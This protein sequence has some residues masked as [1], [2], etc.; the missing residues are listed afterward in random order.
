M[1]KKGELVLS[2]LE[3]WRTRYKNHKSQTKKELP[4]PDYY[5]VL[6]RVPSSDCMPNDITYKLTDGVAVIE[7]AGIFL[8]RLK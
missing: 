7:M 4:E 1:Y 8:R 5:V 2:F 6:E 3:V